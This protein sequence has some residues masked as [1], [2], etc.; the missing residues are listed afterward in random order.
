MNY[1]LTSM[2]KKLNNEIET[3]YMMSSTDYSFIS[4]SIVK[5]VAAYRA[6]ISESVPP[7]VEKALKKKFK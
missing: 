1:S 5:E 7:Y 2:N 4:S 6:D 3:L